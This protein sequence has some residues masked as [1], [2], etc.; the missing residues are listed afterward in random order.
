MRELF[1]IAED[2]VLVVG[3]AVH[4]GRQVFRALADR[5]DQRPRMSVRICLDV[6]RRPGDMSKASG[7]LERFATRFRER[8]WPGAR[9]PE[10]F[11]DPALWLWAK[12]PEPACTP[13]AWSS[14]ATPHLSAQPTSPKPPNNVTSRSA[15][16]SATAMLPMLSRRTLTDSF[17]MNS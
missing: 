2:R 8:E 17:D 10:V 13:N 14:T 4:Q 6:P 16:S 9:L 5:M 11:Y 7:I 15:F 12:V 1:S 3:F